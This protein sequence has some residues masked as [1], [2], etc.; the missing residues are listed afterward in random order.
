[1]NLNGV[2]AVILRYFAEFGRANYVKLVEARPILSATKS[3]PK[4]LQGEH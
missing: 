4:N 2:M 3:M 1:M